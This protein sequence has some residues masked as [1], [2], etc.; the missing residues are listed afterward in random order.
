M[1]YFD[2]TPAGW[3]AAGSTTGLQDGDAWIVTYEINLDDQWRTRSA[4]IVARTRTGTTRKHIEADGAGRWLIDGR[5]STRLGGCLDLDLESSAMTNAFPIHRLA[6]A[7]GESA[8]APASYFRLDSASVERLDQVYSRLEDF[9]GHQQFHY[10]A[11][12]FDFQ[13]R[14]TYDAAGL[15]LDYPGIAVRAA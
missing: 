10:E 14:L 12:A 15:V 7:E 3:R 11:P 2:V 8:N 9:N 5:E 13:C 1:A 4:Q 6:L